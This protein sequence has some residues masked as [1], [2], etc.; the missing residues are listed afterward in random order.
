MHRYDPARQFL[1][2][3]RDMTWDVWNGLP[4]AKR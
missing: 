2:P 1:F 3:G 4:T